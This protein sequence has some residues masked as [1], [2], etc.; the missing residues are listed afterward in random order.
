MLDV[1]VLV[2]VTLAWLGTAAGGCADGDAFDTRVLDLRDFQ[3]FR[4]DQTP[5]LSFLGCPVPYLVDPAEIERVGEGEYVLTFAAAF[6]SEEEFQQ[7]LKDEADWD[8]CDYAEPL[9][10]VPR[11]LKEKEL[12]ELMTLF[13]SVSVNFAP[14]P[15]NGVSADPCSINQLEWDDLTTSDQSCEQRQPWIQEE[16]ARNILEAVTALTRLPPPE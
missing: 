14:D 9:P 5:A 4:V 3:R 8:N 12:A 13:S 1:R 7:C 15:C 16:F 2:S 11:R 6:S 10:G